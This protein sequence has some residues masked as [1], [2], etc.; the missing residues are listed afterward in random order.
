MDFRPPY[1]DNSVLATG[2]YKYIHLMRIPA[3][4]LLDIYYKENKSGKYPDKQLIEYIEKN[5]EKI[6]DR[7][8]K[9]VEEFDLGISTRS[10]N[11]T[12]LI[13]KKTGKIIYATEKIAKE[14]LKRIQSIDQAHKKPIRK[15]E[16]EHCG[17][18]HHTSMTLEEWKNFGKQ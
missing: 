7:L 10:M 8:D 4:Y 14:A 15:F 12:L 18:W 16:C 13:C 11:S 3:Q 17:G 6:K 2:K 9:P 1:T 5:L